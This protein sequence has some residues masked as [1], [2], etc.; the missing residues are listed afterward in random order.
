MTD[1]SNDFLS[2]VTL[3]DIGK[4]TGD[5]PQEN[6]NNMHNYIYGVE[7]IHVYVKFSDCL[8]LIWLKN[9]G[10]SVIYCFIS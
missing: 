6:E 9:T 5:K 4:S 7:V 2:D 10:V 8:P 1:N 3:K